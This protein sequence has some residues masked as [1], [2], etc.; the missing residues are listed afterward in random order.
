MIDEEQFLTPAKFDLIIDNMVAESDEC[1]NH[2]TAVLAYCDEH[3]IDYEVITKV[4][5]KH[6][7]E[8]IHSDAV[9]LNYF[10]KTT[11]SIDSLFGEE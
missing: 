9:A 3:D 11:E 1:L 7:K 2:L 5:S 8:K 4:C 6:M 10:K